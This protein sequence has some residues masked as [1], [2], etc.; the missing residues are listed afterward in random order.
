MGRSTYR[1][2]NRRSGLANEYEGSRVGMS[3]RVRGRDFETHSAASSGREVASRR[4]SD[5]RSYRAMAEPVD[6]PSSGELGQ[7][8]SHADAWGETVRA[9]SCVRSPHH[10]PTSGG[11]PSNRVPART[12]RT[13]TF[14]FR[15]MSRHSPRGET[16][17]GRLEPT[18]GCPSPV[19]ADPE[20]IPGDGHR[21]ADARPRDRCPWSVRE[22]WDALPGLRNRRRSVWR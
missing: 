12:A 16:G 22:P 17:G 10:L 20:S 13:D 21:Q 18:A 19:V 9:I 2:N 15:P 4:V 3:W 7:S 6:P 1:K 8:P 5:R 11:S 14:R